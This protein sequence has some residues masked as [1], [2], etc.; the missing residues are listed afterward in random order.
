MFETIITGVIVFIC[1][2]LIGFF[3]G[4]V[5]V[6]SKAEIMLD[7]L[8]ERM[9]ESEKALEV[10]LEC[11]LPLLVKAKDGKTNGELS[12]ALERLN[13]YLIKK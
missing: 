6:K 3:A 1:T 8:H 7:K 11:L 2:A 13:A 10:I 4:K 12:N 5:S 9:D